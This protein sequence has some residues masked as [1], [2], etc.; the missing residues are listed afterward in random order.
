MHRRA[1]TVRG[2]PAIILLVSII[3]LPYLLGGSLE[4]EE[5][6]RRV[7]EYL[8]REVTYQQLA[9]LESSGADTPDERMALRW[10]EQIDRVNNMEFVSV[11]VK[12]AVLVPPFRR[13]TNF[14]VK[15]VVREEKQPDL[16]LLVQRR[17]QRKR[18]SETGRVP[19]DLTGG[20]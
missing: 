5:A 10:K 19:P 2:I 8:L 7:R 12:R 9:E 6:E 20:D 18:E 11:E 17:K 4:P 3:A 14:A 13:R 16:L 15:V 1:T